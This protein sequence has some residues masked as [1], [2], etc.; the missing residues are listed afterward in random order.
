[1]TFRA[2]KITLSI[3]KGSKLKMVTGE[4]RKYK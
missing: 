3:R 1:M 4:G 2:L